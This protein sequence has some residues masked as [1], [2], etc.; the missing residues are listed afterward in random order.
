MTETKQEHTP[1]RAGGNAGVGR[2]DRSSW[3]GVLVILCLVLLAYSPV[4]HAGF[5]WDDDEYVV[6]NV[7]LQSAAGLG[8]IW[9]EPGATP[10]YY[11]LVFSAFWFQY[12]LWGLDPVG[13]HLVNILIH[14]ANALLLWGGLRRLSLP[15]AFF[16][17]CLFAVHPVQVE[18]AAWVTELKN[19]L[20]LFF[21]LLAFHAYWRGFGDDGA[22]TPLRTRAIAWLSSFGCFALALFSKT[23]SGSLPAAILLVRWWRTGRVCPRELARLS[24][25][26]VLAL[27]LGRQTAR[28]EVTHVLARGPE[29]DFSF[30]ERVLIAGRSLCFYVG[31]LLWPQPLIFNYPRWQIDA[32]AWWQYLF[33]LAVVSLLA[34]LWLLRQKIGR[35][36]LA[37]ALFF[38]G[39]LFPAIGFFNVYPMRFSFVAD[40][41]QYSAAIGIF[42]LCG[43]GLHLVRRKLPPAA[44]GG[45][46]PLGAALIL[47]LL[48]LTWQQ[49]RIYTDKLTLFSDTLAKNPASWFSYSNRATYY[50]NAGEDDLALTDI[51]SSLAIKPD[52]ADALHLRGVIRI[53]RKQYPEGL[54]DFDRSIALR[55][56][57]TDYLRN[58]CLSYR[59]VGQTDR[60]LADADLLVSQEPNDAGNYLLRASLHLLREAYPAALADLNRALTL[61]PDDADSWAN[62][63]LVYFRQGD[64]PRALADYNR[65]LGMRPDSAAT[66]YNRGLTL[67]AAG[68]RAEASADLEQAKRLGF[69][70]HDREFA[71]ILAPENQPTVRRP[72]P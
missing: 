42:A 56:W 30:V 61:D 62:R 26:F 19:V 39:T 47:L 5:I 41:F 55:P 1:D 29:W 17:A 9:L 54:A 13:Y 21:Y 20:S 52:E 6:N 22:D 72:T 58:R 44:A 50:A 68:R 31:K 70:I 34:A 15:G 43:A 23:V 4:F 36:P 51:A 12:H 24:P 48:I 63:G 32:A 14:G 2:F 37:G 71:R 7:H 18:S 3:S 64:L 57:R 59:H 40:H 66:L 60:A 27:L 65:A 11:P 10:Q 38:C 49:G 67:A 69:A 35:G 8:S 46:N 53:K 45:V 28:L 25:F 16:A 33:P